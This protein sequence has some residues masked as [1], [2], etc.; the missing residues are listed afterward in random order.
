MIVTKL[1]YVNRHISTKA[2]VKRLGSPSDILDV[3]IYA[4]GRDCHKVI[5]KLQKLEEYINTV[6]YDNSFRI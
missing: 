6:C 4:H 1:N 5:K 2:K 3:S